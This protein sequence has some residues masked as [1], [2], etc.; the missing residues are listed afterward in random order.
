MLILKPVKGVYY[1]MH[2]QFPDGHLAAYR[3]EDNARA[4]IQWL[5]VMNIDLHGLLNRLHFTGLTDDDRRTIAKIN[6][7]SR[8]MSRVWSSKEPIVVT[9]ARG[10]ERVKS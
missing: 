6:R 3:D 9:L 5:T 1:V 2:N 4:F 7:A 10:R 8:H